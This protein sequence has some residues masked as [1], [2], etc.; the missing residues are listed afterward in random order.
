MNPQSF[1]AL[2]ID[3]HLGELS[4]EAGELLDLHLAQNPAARSEAERILQS[5]AATGDAMHQHPELSQVPPVSKS[6]AMVSCRRSIA[7]WMMRAAALMLLTLTAATLGFVTGRA[8]PSSEGGTGTF[9]AVSQSSAPTSKSSPWARYRVT[10]D[11][12]GSG[13]QVVRV[14]VPNSEKKSL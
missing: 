3:R 1:H 12:A 8:R 9:A 4:P 5:L 2:I 14:D 11:P 6:N 10:Y 13:M 7:P